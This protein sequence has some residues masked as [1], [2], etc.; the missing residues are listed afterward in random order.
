MRELLASAPDT[1]LRVLA[2]LEGLPDDATGALA[3]GPEGQLSGVVL[4]E[5]GRVCWAA[6]QGLRRRLTD[7]LRQRCA[8]PLTEGE[9]ESLVQVCRQ[10]GT[11][12]GETLV[13]AGHLAPAALRNAL[14]QHT[15]ESLAASSAWPTEPR[16]VPHRAR[17]YLSAY[18]FHPVE[19]LT[20]ASTLEHGEA[21]VTTAYERLELVHG[22]WTAAVFDR[23]GETL[24]ACRLCPGARA[25]LQSLRQAG[26]WAAR[27]LLDFG[28]RSEV[29]KFAFDG[30]GGTWVGWRDGGFTT[31]AHCRHRDE[32][33]TLMRGLQRLG[34]TS[35]V[36]S[37]EPLH[38]AQAAAP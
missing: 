27:N 31:L 28:Q 10:R 2:E 29:V 30:R 15:T 26:A 36:H 9:V 14:L 7:L 24:L 16:W 37:S 19:I 34:W 22:E 5:Q 17:G 3:Y 4:L 6:S 38:A 23:P 11:P 8:P 20:W 1:V 32:F 18:T 21:L 35:A 33:S 12:V 13:A 25:E